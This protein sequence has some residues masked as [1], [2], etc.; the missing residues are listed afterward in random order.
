MSYDSAPTT[1]GSDAHGHSGASGT[2]SIY[3]GSSRTYTGSG[4]NH[5]GLKHSHN[6]IIDLDVSDCK[7]PYVQLIPYRLTTTLYSV[8]ERSKTVNVD[9][10]LKLIK[11]KSMTVDTLIKRSFPKTI[12]ESAQ[13]QKS[14]VAQANVDALARKEFVSSITASQLIVLRSHAE[15][16][17]SA[18]CKAVNLISDVD[19]GGLIQR[20]FPSQADVVT[21][22]T[23]RKSSFLTMNGAVLRT[24][25]GEF[26]GAAFV[27]RTGLS[28][29][30]VD[31]MLTGQ[32][33]K[34]LEANAVVVKPVRRVLNCGGVFLRTFGSSFGVGVFLSDR[35]WRTQRYPLRRDEAYQRRGVV[36]SQGAD[37]SQTGGSPGSLIRD[38][39]SPPKDDT[40]PSSPLDWDKVDRDPDKTPGKWY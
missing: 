31:T 22:L 6:F 35:P 37:W 24:K 40:P 3:N 27:S 21:T 19:V 14:L 4:Y 12:S 38:T 5:C 30:D 36:R 32:Y 26:E 23:S 8:T 10:L 16:Q 13:V 17:G 18:L 34:E 7:P 39:I 20:E 2:S 25:S 33:S 28:S 29:I 11:S 9:F 15:I 1:E